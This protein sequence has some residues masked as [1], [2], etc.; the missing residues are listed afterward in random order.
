MIC[1]LKKEHEAESLENSLDSSNTVDSNYQLFKRLFLNIFSGTSETSE[2]QYVQISTVLLDEIESNILSLDQWKTYIGDRELLDTLKTVYHYFP[3]TESVFTKWL[4]NLYEFN[5]KKQI[6]FLP[7][8]KKEVHELYP[9]KENDNLLVI[10]LSSALKRVAL[11]AKNL[12]TVKTFYAIKCCPDEKLVELLAFLGC[13]FDCASKAEI[14]HVMSYG[15]DSSR[16]IY[17]NPV[18]DPKFIQFAG[19]HKLRMTF[20]C[21][22]ELKK[23]AKNYPGAELVMRI[24]TDDSHSVLRFSTKFGCSVSQAKEFLSLAKE[25]GLKIVGVSFHVG[26]KC[27]NPISYDKAI[28]D[29]KKIFELGKDYG[30]EMTMLDI[31][32]GFPGT[33]EKD[34]VSFE[35]M[36]VVINASV[37]KHFSEHKN[38]E[39]IAEPG[40]F[41]AM[42]T[43]TLYF[44]VIGKKENVDE[45]GD[46]TFIYYMNDGVYGSFNCI[47]YDQQMPT[48]KA[49]KPSD[50]TYRS[51]IFGPT[52]DSMDRIASDAQLP[53]LEIGDMCYVEEFG[54]YTKAAATCF[55]GFQL[56]PCYYTFP[57]L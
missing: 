28:E 56:V 15:V 22:E 43:H 38:L 49:L 13:S 19:Q 52:C 24:K 54:A 37:K 46:K 36:A 9:V 26:S 6:N 17:A 41:L 23:V 45:N 27:R 4:Q 2:T 50:Q 55:N 1:T 33:F 57:S 18:K 30:M 48:V 42:K 29:A 44:N 16:I 51:I 53:E 20:D 21:A 32:G 47:I 34:Y 5:Q 10:D 25:L 31:G 39:L 7:N 35:D 8:E 3:K 12:P 14:E 11:W 40:R